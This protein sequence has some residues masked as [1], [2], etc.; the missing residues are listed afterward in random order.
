MIKNLLC[1]VSAC[2]LFALFNLNAQNL[3]IDPSFENGGSAWQMNTSG[4]RS[5]V[6]NVAHTGTHSEQMIIPGVAFPRAVWQTVIDT[7]MAGTLYDASG[8]LETDAIAGSTAQIM[9]LWFNSL[10]PPNNQVP[11]G[12]IR[13][14]T[15]GKLSGTHPWT[16]LSQTFAAPANAVTAQVYLECTAAAGDTGTAWF[17]D[18]SFQVHP[19]VPPSLISAVAGEQVG[20]NDDYVLLTFDKGVTNLTVTALNI[21]SVIPLSGGH[22]WLSG[23]G[24]I[25]SAVWN[26]T[27]TKLLITLSVTVSAPTISVGDTISFTQGQAQSKAVL[28]GSFNS[29]AS[30]RNRITSVSTNLFRVAT[31]SGSV[32]FSYPERVNVQIVDVRGHCIAHLGSGTVFRWD[33]NSA[34]QHAAT[35]F[36]FA[37]LTSNEHMVAC[38]RFFIP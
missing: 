24:T 6:N 27:F 25:G 34:G 17:D 8:W 16:N 20:T 4:G 10:T 19:A 36:Y 26:P 14:D 23:F 35:G 1:R 18:L 28:T 31:T 5:I 3:L 37:Q 2:L 11:A 21:D 12:Y 15:V 7:V 33:H 9:I 29:A 22:T 30:V 13:I 38:K 32:S